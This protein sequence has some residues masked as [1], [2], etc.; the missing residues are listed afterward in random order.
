MRNKIFNITIFTTICL[1]SFCKGQTI[2]KQEKGYF[3]TTEFGYYVGNHSL[4]INNSKGGYNSYVNGSYSLSLRNI[5]GLFITNKISL[6]IGVGLENYSQNESNANDNLFQLFADARYYFRNEAS[7]FFVY[8]QVG[9]S[10]AITDRHEKGSMYNLGLGHKFKVGAKTAMNASFGF[11]DQ[12]I[13]TDPAVLQ[14]RYYG[15]ALKAG[16]LF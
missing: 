14:N 7:T 3:N 13:T 12:Y 11:I 2:T 4:K 5:N 16:L 1:T 15:I 9:P 10:I 6:G 8:G